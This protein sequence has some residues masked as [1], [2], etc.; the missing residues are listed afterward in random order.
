ML[1]VQHLEALLIFLGRTHMDAKEVP[2]FVD[3]T[4]RLQAMRQAMIN[5]DPPRPQRP[6]KA[7]PSAK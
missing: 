3:C 4:N 2:M 6:R 7:A 5:P 1:E